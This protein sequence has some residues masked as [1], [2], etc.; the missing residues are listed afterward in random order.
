MASFPLDVVA[1]IVE[2][3]CPQCSPTNSRERLPWAGAYCDEGDGDRDAIRSLASLCLASR[4][5][6]AVATP[7]LYHR[8]TCT[9]W[10]LLAR[11]LV[12]RPD[13]ARR[14]RHLCARD[15]ISADMS[16]MAPEVVRIVEDVDGG[17]DLGGDEDDGAFESDSTALGV[18]LP[19][20]P[21]LEELECVFY[22]NTF[23]CLG[24]QAL[25]TLTSVRVAY[26]DTEGGLDLTE[27]RPLVAAAPNIRL[28]TALLVA[29]CDGQVDLG[30]VMHLRII[31]GAVSW[32]DMGH[33]LRS[34]PRLE[35][36][37]YIAG[38]ATVGFD[39]FTPQELQD[40]LEN[41]VPR[42]KSLVLDMDES[43]GTDGEFGE[44]WVMSSLA[45]L[46]DLQRLELDTRSFVPHREPAA[47]GH[48]QVAP[49]RF[50]PLD[51]VVPSEAGDVLVRLVPD[52]VRELRI[53]SGA[54]GPELGWLKDKLTSLSAAAKHYKGLKR[55]RLEGDGSK[56]L[57]SV[58]ASFRD[59]GIAFN[60]QVY[61]W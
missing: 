13:L 47:R 29:G 43:E 39:Q 16:E 36:F 51:P 41:H 28:L 52:S 46:K 49:R 6:S 44:Q 12:A 35:A 56:D 37:E 40:A 24:R 21:E 22:I 9:E 17:R 32:D 25:P 33:M 11:T 26:S 48:V 50:V 53:S 2:A 34:C 15:W 30:S 8:P 55:I 5:L 10:P 45:G 58:G 38:S 57:E 59:R 1:L 27:L 60:C 61:K 31:L 18:V 54:Y 19:L 7:H 3:I 14:V 20:C 42:L 23:S 4:E